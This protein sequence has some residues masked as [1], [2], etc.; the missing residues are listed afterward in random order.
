MV[1]KAVFCKNTKEIIY[2][3]SI[4]DYRASSDGNLAVDGGFDYFK[5][6]G[7]LDDAVLIYLDGDILLQQILQY[8]YSLGNSASSH[9]NYPNGYHG[10]FGITEKSNLDFFKKLV[11]NYGDIEEYL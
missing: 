11:V 10:R 6:N 7:N 5:I 2:S 4:H 8:D 9:K 3:R 1:I